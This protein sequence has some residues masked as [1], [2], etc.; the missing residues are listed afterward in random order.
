MIPALPGILSSSASSSSG[1]GLVWFYSET[2]ITQSGG[3]VSA[4]Q[5]SNSES[6]IQA[7]SSKQ[8][9]LTANVLNGFPTVDFDGNNDSLTWQRTLP[10][11]FNADTTWYFVLSTDRTSGGGS[12]DI[13]VSNNFG[14]SSSNPGLYQIWTNNLFLPSP[15]NRIGVE[16]QGGGVTGNVRYNGQ[17]FVFATDIFPFQTFGILSIT[18][19]G[20]AY[21][22]LSFCEILGGGSFYGKQRFAAIGRSDGI[23]SLTERQAIE[24]DLSAKYGIPI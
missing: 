15:T 5:G 18:T 8:P 22:S 2:G 14:N 16:D 20:A 10:A 1:G 6:I 7:N 24:A 21:Q 12:V 11:T 4:W 13:V 9:V 3:F 23:Q 19:S 17:P